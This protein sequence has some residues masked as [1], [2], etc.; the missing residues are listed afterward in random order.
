M[1][2]TVIVLIL[3]EPPS[4]TDADHGNLQD[5]G[6]DLWNDIYIT[7]CIIFINTI[8]SFSGRSGFATPLTFGWNYVN[9]SNPVSN[10]MRLEW[11]GWGLY[12]QHA[13]W[14]RLPSVLRRTLLRLLARM[15]VAYYQSGYYPYSMPWYVLT[16]GPTIVYPSYSQSYRY[17][18]SGYY[19]LIRV[20]AS[21]FQNINTLLSC[22]ID[23]HCIIFTM[24]RGRL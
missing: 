17:P 10:F 18:V 12:Q 1:Y 8:N 21:Q 20:F 5:I 3:C 16:G 2:L 11:L 9:T 24:S 19:P 4:T 13:L 7:D 6:S 23:H 22:L 15:E 14:P